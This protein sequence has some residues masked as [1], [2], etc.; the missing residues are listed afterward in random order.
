MRAAGANPVL[1]CSDSPRHRAHGQVPHPRVRVPRAGPQAVHG[2][3]RRH[4]GHEQCQAF[5]LPGKQNIL[6]TL[7]IESTQL[8]FF[9]DSSEPTMKRSTCHGYYVLRTSELGIFVFYGQRRK[10]CAYCFV[11]SLLFEYLRAS[12]Y[13][14][15]EHY[16]LIKKLFF[17]ITAR[18]HT[19]SSGHL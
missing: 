19:G 9:T 12:K 11:I 6:S 7:W 5:P 17:P 3:L 4:P 8:V 14:I 10:A 1:W 18:A 2:R 15:T 16:I 13:F